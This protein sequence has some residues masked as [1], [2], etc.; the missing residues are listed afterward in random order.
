MYSVKITDAYGHEVEVEVSKEIYQFFK[1]EHRRTERGRKEV[2]RH[3]THD[4]F[5]D[6]ILPWMLIICQDTPEDLAC[7]LDTF[8]RALQECTSCQRERFILFLQGFNYSEIARMQGCT[9]Q[10]VQSSVADVIRT[11]Q[12]YFL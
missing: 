11:I 3:F 7:V 10:G 9:K 4:P 5:D 1:T 6:N 8:H 2:Y 12:K